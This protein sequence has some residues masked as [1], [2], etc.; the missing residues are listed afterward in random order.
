MITVDLLC[1]DGMSYG[2][3]NNSYRSLLN[4]NLKIF[5]F[6][7]VSKKRGVDSIRQDMNI[8]NFSER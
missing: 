4:K 7:T 3:F 5:G 6:R 1:R 2:L 8:D